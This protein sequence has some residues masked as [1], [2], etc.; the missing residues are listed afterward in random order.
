VSRATIAEIDLQAL[1]S[2]WKLLTS[3]QSPER[4]I[5]VIKANAYGHGAEAIAI[6][7]Q[8]WQVSRVAVAMLEEAIAVRAAGYVGQILILGPVAKSEISDLIQLQCTP[9]IGDKQCLLDLAGANFNYP[10]HIK[11]DTGMN[12]LGLVAKDIDWLQTFLQRH[13]GIQVQAFCTHFLKADDFGQVGGYCERQIEQFQKIEKQFPNLREK[14]IF[15]TDAFFANQKLKRLPDDYGARTGLSLYGFSGLHLESTQ[16]LQPVMT[17]KS[18]IVHLARVPKGESVSYNA[19]WTA[20][21]DSTIAVLPIGYADGYPRSL[22]NKG[23]VF[24]RDRL[25]PLVGIVCMDYVMIDVTDVTQIELGDEAELW[26]KNLSL[27]SLAQA[28]NTIPY[29]LMTALTSRV[30][31]KI[32]G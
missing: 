21:R 3:F 11:W 25:V 26:G 23:Q 12:R 8:D 9:I 22:S 18:K 30:P 19:A 10:V 20:Q 16:Q 6:K 27:A 32:L 31:R 13:E 5:P 2:N 17:L 1:A 7:L 4:L 15:N 24:V 28:A 29:E 14:H